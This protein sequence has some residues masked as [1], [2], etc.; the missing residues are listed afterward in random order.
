M[1]PSGNT[2][3]GESVTETV[4]SA[5]GVV[6][7]VFSVSVLFG[8]FVSSPV[9]LTL[10]FEVMV[11]SLMPM[12]WSSAWKTTVKLSVPGAKEGRVHVNVALMAPTDGSVHVHPA[13]TVA[14]TKRSGLAGTTLKFT[15]VAVS[16]PLLET[17]ML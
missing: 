10:K 11:V 17:A 13:G 16:G 15:L 1:L 3:S 5:S 9:P 12:N 14:E 8:S 7:A 2:G 4:M 6:Y